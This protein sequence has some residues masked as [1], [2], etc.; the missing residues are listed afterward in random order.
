MKVKSR[1]I[2]VTNTVVSTR[3]ETGGNHRG[4]RGA[5]SLGMRCEISPR[6]TIEAV[7]KK[8]SRQ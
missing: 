6:G 7:V 3:T 5:L 2:M 4:A 8:E 1:D